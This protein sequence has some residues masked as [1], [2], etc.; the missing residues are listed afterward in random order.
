MLL[1]YLEYML[2]LFNSKELYGAPFDTDLDTKTA[3][4][5]ATKVNVPKYETFVLVTYQ[6]LV[7]ID[8]YPIEF[9]LDKVDHSIGPNIYT[10]NRL[11]F[12]LLRK[13][14]SSYYTRLLDAVHH[15]RTHSTHTVLNIYTPLLGWCQ[16]CV[17]DDNVQTSVSDTSELKDL[18]SVHV[19]LRCVDTNPLT[20]LG[21]YSNITLVKVNRL[22][23]S[24]STNVL[25]ETVESAGGISGSNVTVT[26]PLKCD[27]LH[28][29]NGRDILRVDAGGDTSLL[30]E[31]DE[32]YKTTQ[33][34][35]TTPHTT[36]TLE[37]IKFRVCIR[38]MD[39]ASPADS[40]L[41]LISG[42]KYERLCGLCI[43]GDNVTLDHVEYLLTHSPVNSSIKCFHHMVSV[44]VMWREQYNCFD[45]LD[46][47]NHYTTTFNPTKQIVDH[48]KHIQL[49]V[50]TLG[51]EYIHIQNPLVYY[52]TSLNSLIVNRIP[53]DVYFM[54]FYQLPSHIKLSYFKCFYMRDVILTTIDKSAIN[55]FDNDKTRYNQNLIVFVSVQSIGY[56]KN[57][58]SSNHGTLTKEN[59]IYK[60]KP[61]TKLLDITPYTEFTQLK[62]SSVQRI[63]SILNIKHHS[64]DVDDSIFV[65]EDSMYI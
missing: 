21:M 26:H 10:T 45:A 58:L 14:Y 17:Y 20:G 15:I 64:A 13:Y 44:E 12:A 1:D 53:N 52:A 54:N 16:P 31:I 36:N 24:K 47:S 30:G 61:A 18:T 32:Y 19:L 7:D 3:R 33:P 41:I 51:S 59:V 56:L 25:K 60:N 28:T 5:K 62:V 55:I 6:V 37:Y 23:T 42:F 63:S 8:S 22:K 2:E 65:I 9:K 11:Y 39:P 34:P 46:T 38:C 29:V 43:T 57:L 4:L 40:M 49:R 35:S 50:N 27:V 48:L